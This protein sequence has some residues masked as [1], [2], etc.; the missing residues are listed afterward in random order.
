MD[1][2]PNQNQEGEMF[3]KFKNNLHNGAI[4]LLHDFDFGNINAKLKDLEQMII[5]GKTKGYDFVNVQNIL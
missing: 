4:V 1:W 3:E 2:D 5:Y